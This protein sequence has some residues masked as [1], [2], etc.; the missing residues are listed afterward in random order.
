VPSSSFC[1]PSLRPDAGSTPATV[2]SSLEIE[3]EVRVDGQA[4]F[5]V[6]LLG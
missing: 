4:R 1:T 6:D 5:V 2:S 3:H